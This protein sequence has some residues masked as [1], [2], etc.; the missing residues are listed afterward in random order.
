MKRIVVPSMGAVNLPF[1]LAAEE[2]VAQNLPAG[3]YFFA[4]Q[5]APTVICGRH[6]DIAAEVDLGY[7][8]RQ[9]IYVCRRKSGG[10]SVYADGSN[11]MFSYITPS[12]GVQITFGRYTS[13]VCGMLRSLGIEAEATGRNDIAVGGRKVAGNAFLKLPGRSIVHGTMLYDADFATMGRVLTPSRAKRQSKGV[14]SVPSRVTTLRAEGLSIGCT[15]FMAHAVVRLCDEGE[16][17][18]TEADVEAVRSIEQSYYDPGFLRL[19]GVAEATHR[20]EP[21]YIEGVGE[22]ALDLTTDSRGLI[23]DVRLRG[24]FFPLEPDVEVRLTA[25]LAGKPAG[26]EVFR[27]IRGRN[28]DETLPETLIAGLSL[29]D[30]EQ[31]LPII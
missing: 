23:S 27:S 17:R 6:Q 29:T 16:Y 28:T 15:E 5:V 21:V 24:D 8:S 25:M 2:W 22:I 4:W 7:A 9:G 10:G 18:L 3:E 26:R 20:G 30:L 13:M 12:D 1:Y 11:V 14:V 31:L 19:E